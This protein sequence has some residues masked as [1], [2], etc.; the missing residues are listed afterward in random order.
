MAE[1]E[2]QSR[3]LTNNK[4]LLGGYRN[5]SWYQET[6]S[7]GMHLLQLLSLNLVDARSQTLACN[8]AKNVSPYQRLRI[9]Y[10]SCSFFCY[11]IYFFFFFDGVSGLWTQ[12]GIILAMWERSN[13]T[14]PVSMK[15]GC[16]RLDLSHTACILPGG[17]TT[18]LPSQPSSPWPIIHISFVL[19]LKCPQYQG[20]WDFAD[21]C[22]W[23]VWYH[24]MEPPLWGL[25]C[26]SLLNRMDSMGY[27]WPQKKAMLK[28]CWNYCT[29]ELYW[30]PQQR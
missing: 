14:C 13:L 25:L 5:N 24:I 6:P 15:E 11:L 17:E 3:H 19:I 21:L 22:L 4:I 27:I 18:N 12:R 2:R 29:M 9:L 10:W 28:W 23:T 8:C 30:R 7:G 20:Q 1:C 16:V 26:F